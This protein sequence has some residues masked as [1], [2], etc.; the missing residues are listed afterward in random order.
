[1]PVFSQV[2]EINAFAI[3]FRPQIARWPRLFRS[4][5]LLLYGPKYGPFA[6]YIADNSGMPL[7]LEVSSQKHGRISTL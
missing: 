5:V 7:I 1:M 6:Q 4:L 2:V 3:V